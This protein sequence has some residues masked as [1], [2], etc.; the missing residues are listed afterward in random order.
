M[1]NCVTWSFHITLSIHSK[2]VFKFQNETDKTFW[3]PN[4]DNVSDLPLFCLVGNL[5]CGRILKYYRVYTG[6]KQ[7]AGK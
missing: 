7:F 5:D 4:L 3:N 1:T 2:M 6:N